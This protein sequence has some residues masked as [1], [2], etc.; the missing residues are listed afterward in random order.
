MALINLNMLQIQEIISLQFLK[1]CNQYGRLV[2]HCVKGARRYQQRKC[3]FSN[4]KQLPG[5]LKIN[6]F[7]GA[8]STEILPVSLPKDVILK[9]DIKLHIKHATPILNGS[10]KTWPTDTGPQNTP[11]C[12]AKRN[13]YQ[14]PSPDTT[15]NPD[16]RYS[17]SP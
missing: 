6:I 5:K 7:L 17:S 11:L 3:T 10:R 13:T 12:G 14:H 15:L 4:P 16:T 8:F 1:G 2:F 9:T